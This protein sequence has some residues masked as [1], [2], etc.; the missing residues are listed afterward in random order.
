[1]LVAEEEGR[2]L[3]MLGFIEFDACVHGD[4]VPGGWMTNWLVVPE[5]RGRRLGLEL[6]EAALGSRY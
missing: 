3:G 1:V 4:R 2:L 6:V 5:A